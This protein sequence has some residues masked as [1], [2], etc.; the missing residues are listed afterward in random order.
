MFVTYEK[1]SDQKGFAGICS[2]NYGE[3][4]GLV[5]PRRSKEW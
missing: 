2:Q 5:D 3:T 1:H 4:S